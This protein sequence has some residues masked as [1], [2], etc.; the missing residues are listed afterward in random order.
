MF[1]V[2]RQIDCDFQARAL[3]Q[4]SECNVTIGVLVDRERML[5]GSR[6]VGVSRRFIGC[7]CRDAQREVGRV[8][9]WRNAHRFLHE[10]VAIVDD[11]LIEIGILKRR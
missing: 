4:T 6:C 8:S 5:F 7:E 3:E 2:F 1:A 10:H 9:A 11:E